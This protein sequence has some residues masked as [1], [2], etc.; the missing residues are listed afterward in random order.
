L[1]FVL[2]AITNLP[3][4]YLLEGERKTE[5]ADAQL[6]AEAAYDALVTFLTEAMAEIQH[7]A[8][9]WYELLESRWDEAK[10]KREEAERLVAEANQLIS[11]AER[12]RNWLD[13]ET[14]V[15][16]LGHYPFAQ[17]GIPALPEY[18]PARFG[19][20]G[21]EPVEEPEPVEAA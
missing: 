2:P 7:R 16:A 11:E 9:E 5:I 8:P 20:P 6:R 10:A 3:S 21:P 14:G 18:E 13:R 19:V 4:V 17:M 12:M 1:R 15:S